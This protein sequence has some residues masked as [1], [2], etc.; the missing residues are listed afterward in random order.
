MKIQEFIQGR[1]VS[2]QTVRKYVVSH[3]EFKGHIGKPNNI[4]L[5]EYAIQLLN[6]KYP[7]PQ[8]I[9]VVSDTKARQELEELKSKLL[10][11]HERYSNVLEE[12][13]KLHQENANLMLHYHKQALLEEEIDRLK[14]NSSILETEMKKHLITEVR[15][16]KAKDTHPKSKYNIEKLIG[17][18]IEI[19]DPSQSLSDAFQKLHHAIETRDAEQQQRIKELEEQINKEK[20]KTWWDKL[21]GR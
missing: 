3:S 7:L 6:E 21:I 5:D 19:N 1:N 14:D 17:I 13:K 9:Q 10:I 20:S 18:D 11:L 16:I 2:Y 4:I 12:N 15:S 8:P